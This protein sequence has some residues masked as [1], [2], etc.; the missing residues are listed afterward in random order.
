[1]KQLLCECARCESPINYG[2]AYISVARNIE[3]ANLDLATNYASI[4]VIDSVE[5]ITLCAHCGNAFDA[6]AISK[7]VKAIPDNSNIGSN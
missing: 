4:T 2:E 6:D 5:I 3:Q 7:I 1:M